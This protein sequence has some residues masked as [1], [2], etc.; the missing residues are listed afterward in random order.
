[1]SVMHL[2]FYKITGDYNPAYIVP[3][4]GLLV[5]V[6]YGGTQKRCPV[7]VIW[8]VTKC[9]CKRYSVFVNSMLDSA[10]LG[11][12]IYRTSGNFRENLIFAIFASDLKTRKYVSAKNCT[13]KESLEVGTGMIVCYI[14]CLIWNPDLIQVTIWY[15]YCTNNL[16]K[17]A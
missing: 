11:K 12:A 10:N 14:P 2:S 5:D 7:S 15:N 4:F 9:A 1:M 8:Y 6:V 13:Y 16:Y 3:R 17:L